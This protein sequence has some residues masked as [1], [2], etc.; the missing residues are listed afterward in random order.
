MSLFSVPFLPRFLGCCSVGVALST[1]RRKLR[2]R[3]LALRLLRCFKGQHRTGFLHC[4]T[5]DVRRPAPSPISAV[6]QRATE[7]SCPCLCKA[8]M[9]TVVSSLVKISGH[10]IFCVS[11]KAVCEQSRKN[12]SVSFW[13][14][15][16]VV[17]VGWEKEQRGGGRALLTGE[18]VNSQLEEAGSEPWLPTPNPFSFCKLPCWNG[19]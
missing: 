2:R 18:L 7:Q 15:A 14:S 8:V 13:A 16:D 19:W 9:P 5:V 4:I 1:K 3:V 17:E 11:S 12:E 10:E 6:V